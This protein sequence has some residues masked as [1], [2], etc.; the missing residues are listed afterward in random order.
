MATVGKRWVRS[1]NAPIAGVC[2]G[3]AHALGID[4]TVMRIIWLVA[5]LCFGLSIAAYLVLW[6]FLPR[7]DKQF[8]PDAPIFLGVCLRLARK[9]D[10]EVSIVRILTVL[11]PIPTFGTTIILY[12]VAHLILPKIEVTQNSKVGAQSLGQ[13]F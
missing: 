12:F 11:L 3:L 1:Q 9:F 6:L 4:P 5:T 7:E 13:D 8:E 2:G 10:V